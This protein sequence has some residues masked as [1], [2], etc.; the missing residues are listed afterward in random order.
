MHH[1]GSNT[2]ELHTWLGPCR[3]KRTFSLK[4][5][6]SPWRKI[7]NKEKRTLDHRRFLMGWYVLFFQDLGHGFFGDS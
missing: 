7:I 2:F 6:N 3:E 1:Q 4:R 5:K